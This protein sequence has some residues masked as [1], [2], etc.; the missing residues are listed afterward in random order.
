[1]FIFSSILRYGQ[2]LTNGQYDLKVENKVLGR[3]ESDM[4]VV[5]L[6][7]TEHTGVFVKK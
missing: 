6:E 3:T 2:G 1:M 5:Q 7:A 4:Q